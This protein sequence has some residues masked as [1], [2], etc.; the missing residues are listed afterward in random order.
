MNELY[1][2]KLG[3]IN[4]K[5]GWLR[6][7]KEALDYIGTINSFKTKDRKN[8][9]RNITMSWEKIVRILKLEKYDE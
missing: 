3:E 2:S 7:G 9:N 6:W 8:A 4:T 5:K 1:I